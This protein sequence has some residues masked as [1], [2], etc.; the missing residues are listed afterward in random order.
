VGAT[1][2]HWRDNGG[3]NAGIGT[4]ITGTG[5]ATNNFDVSTTNAPSAF[6]YTEANGEVINTTI[7][8]ANNAGWTAFTSGTQA[9]TNGQGFRILVR[10][11]RTLSLTTS[12][13]PAAN[14]TTLSVTGTYP[15]SPVVINVTRAADVAGKGWSLVGNPYPSTISWNA[16]TKSTEITGTYQTFDPASNAYVS[17]NG[18]T[19]SATDNISS[20][21]GFLVFVTNGSSYTSGSITIEEADKVSG[22]GGSFFKTNLKN[23]LKIS[24]KYDS[25]NVDRTFIHFRDQANELFDPAFDAPKLT[26]PGVNLA[27]KDAKGEFYSINSLPLS[28]LDDTKVIP[29]S[30]LN[31]VE[32]TYTLGFEDVKSFDGQ[33]IYLE[34]KYTNTTS[35]LTEGMNYNFTLSSDKASSNDGRFNLIFA[36]KSTGLGKQ[37]QA[38]SFMLFPNP[39]SDKI[40][41]SLINTN[42]GDYNYE[43]YNQLGAQVKAGN[44][45]FNANRAQ[46]IGVE[47][48]STGVYFIKVYNATA[49]QTIKFIK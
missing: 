9:L 37:A 43:I 38:N 13:A 10:G 26:N 29:L 19:G 6:T 8:G 49:T 30:V 32:A 1:A 17:W 47:E 45:D 7:G 23:H 40:N 20:G 15:S 39:A 41:I 21:Q 35:L 14:T 44:L 24:M 46:S 22:N 18:T 34:D 11:D 42:S 28:A 27:S 4:H 5:G 36:K 25:N 16:I 3:S 12:P 48:M 31:S 2:A 33:E